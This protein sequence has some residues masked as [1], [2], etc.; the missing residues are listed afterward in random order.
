MMKLIILCPSLN[1]S[2]LKGKNKHTHSI[3][4]GA[5]REAWVTAAIFMYCFYKCFVPQV[6]RD[7]VVINLSV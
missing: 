7:L 6:K 1:P 3:F 4:W 5:N 2:A